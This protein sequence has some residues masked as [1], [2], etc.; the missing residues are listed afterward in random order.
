ME[1]EIKAKDMAKILVS[2]LRRYKEGDISSQEAYREAYIINTIL[3]SLEV[4]DIQERLAK[5]EETVRYG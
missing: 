3:K 4:S 2:A 5:I 1:N